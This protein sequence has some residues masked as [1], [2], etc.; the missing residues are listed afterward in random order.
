M[1]T[2][3]HESLTSFRKVSVSSSRR[4]GVTVG[5]IL[6]FLA[7]WPVIR[8]HQ[9]VRPWLLAVGGV[10]VLLGL[11]APRLLDPLNHLWF[12]F[13]LLLARITN[14][15]VMGIMYFAAVVP[16]GWFIRLRGHDLLRLR[17]DDKSESYW[18]ERGASAP[19]SALTKQF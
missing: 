2:Q 5:L 7:V 9:P 6:A 8:H 1:A 18:I 4:F 15:I 19:A 16:L 10:L 13:G 14:P 3:S 12:R 11:V 17:H